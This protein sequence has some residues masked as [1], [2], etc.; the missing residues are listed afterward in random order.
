MVVRKRGSRKLLVHVP[1]MQYVLLTNIGS[2]YVLFDILLSWMGLHMYCASMVDP[3]DLLLLV[4]F[5]NI[6][7]WEWVVNNTTFEI[8]LT[9]FPR[10][11]SKFSSLYVCWS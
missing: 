11:G 5:D 10:D 8:S 3:R 6:G 2:M 1:P 7:V 9:V 4:W